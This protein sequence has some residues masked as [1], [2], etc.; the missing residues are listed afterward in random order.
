[1]PELGRETVAAPSSAELIAERTR[2]RIER[3]QE[4]LPAGVM[5]SRVLDG[6]HYLRVVGGSGMVNGQYV[7]SGV[8]LDFFLYAG[9]VTL[10]A[11]DEEGMTY[12]IYPTSGVELP[13]IEVVEAADDA[14]GIAQ[15]GAEGRLLQ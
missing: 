14:S 9:T 1:M 11:M 13:A 7:T 3:R 15:A 5:T 10:R 8:N 6:P 4:T 12:F 2:A